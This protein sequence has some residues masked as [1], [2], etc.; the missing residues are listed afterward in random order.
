[1]HVQKKLVKLTNKKVKGKSRCVKCLTIRSFSDK[2]KDK[3]ELEVVSQL[4]IDW[5]L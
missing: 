1:M 2:I 5:I 4:L 3:Y